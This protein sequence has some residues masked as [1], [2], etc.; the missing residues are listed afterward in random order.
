MGHSLGGGC[1]KRSTSDTEDSPSPSANENGLQPAILLQIDLS[2]FVN[3]FFAST[4][5]LLRLPLLFAEFSLWQ[6]LTACSADLHR[7]ATSGRGAELP[8]GKKSDRPH[9]TAYEPMKR[10]LLQRQPIYPHMKRALSYLRRRTVEAFSPAPSSVTRNFFAS[11]KGSSSP[12][13]KVPTTPSSF[14]TLT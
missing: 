8:S 4:I 3:A 7:M 5:L 2:I 9:P 11:P 13:P 6:I 12:A 10:T 1:L 14:P